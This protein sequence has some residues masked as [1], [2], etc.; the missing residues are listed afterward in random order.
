MW[1]MSYVVNNI[2]VLSRSPGILLG[3]PQHTIFNIF[4][5]WVPVVHLQEL[6]LGY[7]TCFAQRLAEKNCMNLYSCAHMHAHMH[8]YTHAH[9]TLS[10]TGTR[11]QLP[12]HKLRQLWGITYTQVP[13]Y[14]RGAWLETPPLLSSSPSLFC[15]FHSLTCLSWEHLFDKSHA[16]ES[17]FWILSGLLSVGHNLREWNTKGQKKTLSSSL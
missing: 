11:T 10:Q 2:S 3:S 7:W 13:C 8:T 6:S 9:T 12:C 17:S 15:F 4:Q 1:R 14:L 5:W 16:P